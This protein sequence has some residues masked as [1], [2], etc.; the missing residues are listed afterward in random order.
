MA[1]ALGQD[2]STEY[3]TNTSQLSKYLNGNVGLL[4]SS[5]PPASIISHFE[6]ATST[7]FARA[8]TP[9]TRDFIIPAGLVMSL[10]GEI[11]EDDDVPMAHSIEPELRKLGMPT[12]LIKG[13]ITLQ[14]PYV[15]CKEGSIL[16]SRQTRLL[17]LFGCA[18][19]EFK[20]KLL[21]YWSAATNE[22]VEIDDEESM[23]E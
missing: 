23:D 15:V 19:A 21:A 8:G 6:A 13:K 20:V 22:V 17:K 10:G 5:R 12:T 9:A 1:K 4:F 11:A 2:A 14:N 18:T 16:D 7:D 3:A